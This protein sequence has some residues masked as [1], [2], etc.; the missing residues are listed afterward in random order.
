M[1]LETAKILRDGRIRRTPE[2]R[3]ESLDVPDSRCASFSTKWA[4]TKGNAGQSS[5]RWTQS[6]ISVSQGV[7]SHTATCCRRY[8]RWEPY[9]GKPHVRFCAG[10]EVTRVP[11]A[12]TLFAAVHEH[13]SDMPTASSNVRV[14]G[15]SG[16][17]I[18]ALSSSQF[19]PI[20]TWVI[21]V[22][23]SGV[24]FLARGPVAKC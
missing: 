5:T 1:Q 18:P 17:R 3:C 7:G 14:R 4:G 9:A 12:K 16:K 6:R 22:L 19:D 20:R 8:P 10:G 11:T 13:V 15:Q 23:R 21:S 24:P 2:E